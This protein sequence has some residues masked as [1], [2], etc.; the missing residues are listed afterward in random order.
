[1]AAATTA[2]RCSSRSRWWSSGSGYAL[3][4]EYV[5][6]NRE[7]DHICYISDLTSIRNDF[8]KWDISHSLDSIVDE[9]VASGFHR[10]A[11]PKAS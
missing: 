8:P 1:M 4:W 10:L 5:E 3:D 6:E 2:H 11:S 7:G 9:V